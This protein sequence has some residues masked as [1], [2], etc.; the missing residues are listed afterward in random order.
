MTNEQTHA[1]MVDHMM[2]QIVEPVETVDYYCT[3]CREYFRA[4]RTALHAKEPNCLHCGQPNTYQAWTVG[5]E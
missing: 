2:K 4:P 1:E 5:C 3:D